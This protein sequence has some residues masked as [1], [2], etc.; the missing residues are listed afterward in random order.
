MANC[1][2]FSEIEPKISLNT[3]NAIDSFGFRLMTPVQAAT[4]PLFLSNKDVCVEATTGS[5]KTLAFGVPVFEMLSKRSQSLKKYEL[6]A[7]VI[8][9]T[10]ELANQIY[11]VFI[12]LSSF[13]KKFRCV[14]F[15]G[16]T[17]V[18][19]CKDDFEENGAD[20]IIGTPGRIMD[21][22]NRCDKLIKFKEFEVLVLDEADTLLDMGFKEKINEILSL[23]PKQ[24]RTGLF[25]ATQTKEVKELARAGMRNPVTVTVKVKSSLNTNNSLTK[26]N[27]SSQQT[28]PSTLNNLFLICEYEDRPSKLALFLLKHQ[29]DKVNSSI[30]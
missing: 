2:K 28:T 29:K 15:V 21:I 20:I 30:Y 26:P 17:D 6:G 25:S 13:H 4:I 16:G 27:Q 11:T 23:L 22:L 8:A 10:R 1:I 14:L 19:T 9:P 18:D 24:R 5:G 3:L 7:L 12:K